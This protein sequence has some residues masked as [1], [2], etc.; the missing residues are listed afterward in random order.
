MLMKIENLQMLLN[1]KPY[2]K[3]P[4]EE[5]ETAL[6]EA[7]LSKPAGHCFEEKRFGSEE[8]RLMSQIGG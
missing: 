5:L 8:H 2:L 1:L 7:I 3:G 4:D 6:R